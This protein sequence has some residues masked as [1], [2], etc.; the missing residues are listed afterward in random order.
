[1]IQQTTFTLRARARGFHLVTDEVLGDVHRN[2]RLAVINRDGISYHFRNN[3][4][5]AG[6]RLYHLPVARLVHLDHF[7]V[8]AL[9]DEGAFLNRS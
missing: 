7:F 9:L 1:M 6:I 2:P 3:S 4:R 5:A 8:E